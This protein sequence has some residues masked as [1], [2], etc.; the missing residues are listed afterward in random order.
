MPYI[1]VEMYSGFFRS[2]TKY[3]V[4]Q[5]V[6]EQEFRKPSNKKIA[7]KKTREIVFA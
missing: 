3:R 1:N 5:K 7:R 2:T 6:F 4:S